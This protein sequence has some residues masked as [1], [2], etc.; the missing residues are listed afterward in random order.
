MLNYKF[1]RITKMSQVMRRQLYIDRPELKNLS[2]DEQ[3]EFTVS[4]FYSYLGSFGKEMERFGNETIELIFDS[5][6]LQKQW[7]KE[8]N[9]TLDEGKHWQA[10]II[11]EQLKKI[12]PDVIYLQGVLFIDSVFIESIRDQ[13]P[14]LKLVVQ[15]S[16]SPAGWERVH[17]DA[18]LLV[19]TPHMQEQAK[20]NGLEAQLVY[21]GFDEQILKE[22]EKN[23]RQYDF[24]FVGSSGVGIMPHNNRYWDLL[25]LAYNSPLQLWLDEK[26]LVQSECL[27]SPFKKIELKDHFYN[28]LDYNYKDYPNPPCKLNYLL[29]PEKK[30][31]SVHGLD[32]Y[33]LLADSKMTFH[34][35]GDLILNYSGAMRLFEA[36]GVGTCLITDNQSNLSDTFEPDK[37][38]VTYSSL[39]ECVEKVN[40]LLEH[41]EEREAIAL[42]GQQ[43]NLKEHTIR[44]RC[45]QI[46]ELITNKLNSLTH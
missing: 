39:P 43:R 3:F 5:E 17:S 42:A 37:E 36:T 2:Y 21:H 7:A 11:A 40:Y 19:A 15:H 14:N 41:P 22:I 33:Q 4:G 31:I 45:E 44:H 25:K 13:L 24:S 9:I 34:R 1:V 20:E 32:Y 29:P 12:Q 23:K 18:L 38:I 28:E 8:N 30:H 6:F 16:G 27:Y 26:E 10:K 35:H 46:H